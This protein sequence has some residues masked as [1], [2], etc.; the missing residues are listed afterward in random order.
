LGEIQL[1]LYSREEGEYF[2]DHHKKGS[3]LGS[4]WNSEISPS[5]PYDRFMGMRD[6]KGELLEMFLSSL[7]NC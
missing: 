3:I 7:A 4:C 5:P 6:E 1:L 2:G